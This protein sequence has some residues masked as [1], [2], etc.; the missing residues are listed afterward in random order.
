MRPRLGHGADHRSRSLSTEGLG[1]G[2]ARGLLHGQQ[3]VPQL[4]FRH[5]VDRS[6][7]DGHLPRGESAG[8]VHRH[9]VDVSALF[10]G[11]WS[12]QQNAKLRS[13]TRSRQ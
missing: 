4:V 9:D 7:H 10:Q 11:F 3:R 12:G 1:D 8:L 13:S 2:M 5:S 6:A